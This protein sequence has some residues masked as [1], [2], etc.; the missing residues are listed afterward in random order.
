MKFTFSLRLGII[1]SD[2][3]N[4]IGVFDVKYLYWLVISSLIF[5]EMGQLKMI[6][7]FSAFWQYLITVGLVIYFAYL[8][9]LK[10]NLHKFK[11]EPINSA[12]L[13]N[14]Q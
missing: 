8:F 2:L 10:V 9:D 7:E 4:Y 3:I 12:C 5:W 1:L 13:N 14:D 6:F 11:K